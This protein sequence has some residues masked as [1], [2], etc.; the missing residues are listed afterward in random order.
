[1]ISPAT[2][3][4]LR[5]RGHDAVAVAEHPEWRAFSDAEV[6]ALARRERRVVVTANLRDFRPLHRD[7][8][9][10]DGTGHAGLAHQELMA[11]GLWRPD[12]LAGSPPT[13]AAV[14]RGPITGGWLGKL[15][16]HNPAHCPVAEP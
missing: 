13:G 16:R 2:A 9:A 8:V 5:D 11:A 12:A 6:I 3:R 10:L 1:M 14:Q 15:E 4:A 7:L